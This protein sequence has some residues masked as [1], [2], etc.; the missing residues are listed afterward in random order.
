LF[1]QQRKIVNQRINKPVMIVR[2]KMIQEK[3]VFERIIPKII[4]TR[5]IVNHPSVQ[6]RVIEGPVIEMTQ[7]PKIIPAV[8]GLQA[9]TTSE[10]PVVEVADDSDGETVDGDAAVSYSFI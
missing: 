1:V 3:Q 6:S 8:R 4:E 5:Q 9:R 2:R 10:C 7:A